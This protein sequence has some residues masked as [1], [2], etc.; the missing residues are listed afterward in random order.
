MFSL[1]LKLVTDIISKPHNGHVFTTS[2][3]TT[4]LKLRSL[5]ITFPS[6]L[7]IEEFQ[8][9]APNHHFSYIIDYFSL[10]TNLYLYNAV[11]SSSI[12]LCKPHITYYT[13]VKKDAQWSL[14]ITRFTTMYH[15]FF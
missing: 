12:T 11:D 8:R 1:V 6:A 5:S 13:T 7:N 15:P 2:W 3:L 9:Q 14:D 4:Q 10:L